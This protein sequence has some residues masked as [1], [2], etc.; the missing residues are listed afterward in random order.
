MLLYHVVSGKVTAADVVKIPSATTL[1]GKDVRIR[2]SGSNVFVN[3]A[4]VTE[5]RR[6]GVEW[7]DPRG[8]PRADPVRG[9]GENDRGSAEAPVAARSGSP[10][11][12]TPTE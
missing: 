11:A 2:V 7:R 1:N 10:S 12:V 6:H 5:A 3:K 4:K 8:Q 9:V